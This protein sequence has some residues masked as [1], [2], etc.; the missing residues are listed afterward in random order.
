M[1]IVCKMVQNKD[2]WFYKFCVAGRRM[3][4]LTLLFSMILGQLNPCQNLFLQDPSYLIL[5]SNSRIL[6]WWLFQVSF[7][8]V[9]RTD[10]VRKFLHEFKGMVHT[11]WI[12]SS[13]VFQ[14]FLTKNKVK[15][16]F[17]V[18]ADTCLQFTLL[19][20]FVKQCAEKQFFLYTSFSTSFSNSGIGDFLL[21]IITALF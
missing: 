10:T 21:I 18:A 5:F 3:W 15:C 16:S 12:V 11:T 13:M 14:V 9:S 17:F 7:S 4:R 19:L 20:Q 1:C 6:K 8:S 2:V